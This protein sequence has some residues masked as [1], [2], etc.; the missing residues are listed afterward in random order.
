MAT[1]HFIC[2]GRLGI[3]KAQGKDEYTT[4]SWAITDAEANQL[5]GGRIYLHETKG[6][7]SFFGGVV[8][9][10]FHSQRTIGV[11]EEGVTFL[12]VA[13]KEAKGVAW[14]GK[15]HV[16]AWFSAVLD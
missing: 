14:R 3:A 13:D 4:A 15:D 12:I 9:E 7:P 16:M 5:V 8:K 2:K 11:R 1:A 10:W 6:Q